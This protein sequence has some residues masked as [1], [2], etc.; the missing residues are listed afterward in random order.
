M[1]YSD[2][3][4]PSRLSI[5]E[6]AQIDP[7]HAS[8]HPDAVRGPWRAA[9]VDRAGYTY[10]NVGEARQTCGE[11]QIPVDVAVIRSTA[12]VESRIS[13]FKLHAVGAVLYE[14][15]NVDFDDDGPDG[16]EARWA[17]AR[18]V[19]ALLNANQDKVDAVAEFRTERAA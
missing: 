8:D 16:A 18:M 1:T 11:K 3:S 5:F 6:R 9:L 12:P 2:L 4:E 10:R 15:S 14:H 17:Q 19:A 13:P 7:P